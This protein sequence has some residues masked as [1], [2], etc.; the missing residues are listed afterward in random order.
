[1]NKDIEIHDKGELIGRA[2]IDFDDAS[3]SLMAV[4][5]IMFDE[6]KLNVLFIKD[7]DYGVV[8]PEDTANKMREVCENWIVNL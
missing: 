6:R 1:M 2:I 3:K 8:I 7:M 5:E 4:Y